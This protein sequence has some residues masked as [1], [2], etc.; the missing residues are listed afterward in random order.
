VTT[1]I[2]RCAT[3]IVGGVVGVLMGSIFEE[4]TRNACGGIVGDVMFSLIDEQRRHRLSHQCIAP[5]S[6]CFRDILRIRE[7]P[8]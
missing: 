7:L 6:T 5:T 2:G 1:K 4:Q 8:N 3:R